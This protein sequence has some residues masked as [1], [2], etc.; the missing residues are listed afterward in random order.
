MR[1]RF[2]VAVILALLQI[3]GWIIFFVMI[4]THH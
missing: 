3:A 1:W 2:V 4:S